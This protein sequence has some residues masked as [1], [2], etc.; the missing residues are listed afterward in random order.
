MTD[1]QPD[2]I[3]IRKYFDSGNCAAAEDGGIYA[4]RGSTE[5][6]N[7]FPSMDPRTGCFPTLSSKRPR[8][9]TAGF[10]RGCVVRTLR[11]VKHAQVM[12]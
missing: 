4:D 7:G 12:K 5:G 6:S 11:S 10:L 9:V 1:A 8:L 3:E 2:L